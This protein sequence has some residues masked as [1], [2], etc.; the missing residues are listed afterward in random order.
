MGQMIQRNKSRVT[1]IIMVKKISKIRGNAVVYLVEIVG[2][3]IGN[4]VFGVF[5]RVL[6]SE[7]I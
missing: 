6:T 1:E 2:D 5:S 4:K 7:N 3:V